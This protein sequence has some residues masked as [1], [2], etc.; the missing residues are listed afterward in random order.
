MANLDFAPLYRSTIA[1]G[2]QVCLDFAIQVENRVLT[3]E[4]AGDIE[5]ML[6]IECQGLE[7]PVETDFFQMQRTKTAGQVAGGSDDP[8]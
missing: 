5:Q 8:G 2:K 7:R 6:D 4:R 3:L 1:E